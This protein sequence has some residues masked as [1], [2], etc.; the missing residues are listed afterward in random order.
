MYPQRELIRLGVHKAALRRRIARRRAEC[1]EAAVHLAQPLEWLDRAVA[2][3]RRISPF[4]LLAAVPL[5]FLIK[6]TASPKLKL[7]GTIMKWAPIVL[8]AV[9]GVTAAAHDRAGSK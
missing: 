7:L 3:W 5:G 1:V 2:L 8:G 9:R 6:R 4:A